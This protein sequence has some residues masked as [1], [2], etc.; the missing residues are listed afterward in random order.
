M[1]DMIY[2]V[3][4]IALLLTAAY[5]Q[6]IKLSDVPWEKGILLGFGGCVLW[7]ILLLIMKYQKK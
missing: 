1:K 6:D 4:L 7:G 3:L 2:T 5:I